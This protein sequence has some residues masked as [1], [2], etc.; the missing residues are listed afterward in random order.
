VVDW[1]FI[2]FEDAVLVIQFSSKLSFLPEKIILVLSIFTP[3]SRLSAR[4][5]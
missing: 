4:T 2:K 1:I 3:R 5:K